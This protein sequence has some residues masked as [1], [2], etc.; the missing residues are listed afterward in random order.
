[1][2]GWNSKGDWQIE[3]RLKQLD[4]AGYLKRSDLDE[5]AMGYLKRVDTNVALEVLDI[6]EKS[7]MSN[8]RNPSAAMMSLLRQEEERQGREGGGSN[9]WHSNWEEQ[10]QQLDLPMHVDDRALEGLRAIPENEAQRI[11]SSLAAQSSSIRNPSAFVMKACKTLEDKGTVLKGTLNSSG[12]EQ[13][14]YDGESY[15]K[16]ENYREG[17]GHWEDSGRSN[18]KRGQGKSLHDIIDEWVRTL[19]LDDKAQQELTRLE[20]HDQVDLLEDLSKKRADIHNRSAWICGRI[21][22]WGKGKGRRDSGW[23]RRRS[24]SPP[25]YTRHPM[26]Q[27]LDQKAQECVGELEEGDALKLLRDLEEQGDRVRNPSAYVSRGA[28]QVRK[29]IPPSAA[30]QE[31]RQQ[32][33]RSHRRSRSPRRPGVRLQPGPDGRAARS[34]PRGKWSEDDRW[35]SKGGK[36]SGRDRYSK[37]SGGKEEGKGHKGRK[38]K[39]KRDDY[40]RSWQPN[41]RPSSKKHDEEP[42]EG[43][44]E[45]ADEEKEWHPW[46]DGEEDVRSFEEEE[47]EAFKAS[48]DSLEGEGGV[49][50]PM[51]EAEPHTEQEVAESA[52]EDWKTMDL[53][54]WLQSVDAGT[55]TLLEY[56]QNLL[57]SYD[58]L[59]MIVQLYVTAPGRDGRCP[60]QSIFFEDIGVTKVGHKRAFEMWFGKRWKKDS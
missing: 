54:T 41:P 10:L 31:H 16:Q 42:E 38:G 40:S 55:G 20:P 26:W 53:S 7:D 58:S 60:I 11:V 17:R 39:G 24:P 5:M 14:G 32:R 50:A 48:T 37:G 45:G 28:Q 51:E 56:E 36:G 43:A 22:N 12:K 13:N 21:K 49:E 33:S 3:D 47:G 25:Q 23:E 30:L 19:V 9:Q 8:R 29:G 1:M 15:S 44:A 35:R 46:L 6:W 18:T 2:P 52:D 4:R 34:P 59:S 57:D 27:L